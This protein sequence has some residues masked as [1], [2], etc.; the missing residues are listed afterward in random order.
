MPTSMI[1]SRFNDM[2]CQTDIEIDANLCQD[3]RLHENIH[4]PI[5]RFTYLN[6]AVMSYMLFY[7]YTTQAEYFY[8]S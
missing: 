6:F 2:A 3:I 8:I 7:C 4:N 5:P 1:T